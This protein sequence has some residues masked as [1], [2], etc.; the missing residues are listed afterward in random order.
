MLLGMERGTTS[1]GTENCRNFV[2]LAEFLNTMPVN[3]TALPGNYCA[4]NHYRNGSLDFA[5]RMRVF[6]EVS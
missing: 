2:T 5:N 6:S 3:S 1:R 4:L